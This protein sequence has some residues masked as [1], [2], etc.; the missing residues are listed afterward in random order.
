MKKMICLVFMIC[1]LTQMSTTYAESN[2]KLDY[3]SNRNKSFVSEDVFYKQLDK[4][5]YKEYDNAAYS[6]RKKILFKEVPDEEFSFLQKTAAGCRSEVMLHESFIHPNRQVYFFASFSQNEVKEL[7]KY[8]VI[9]AETKRELRE[10][11]SYHHCN[12]LY[13]K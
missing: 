13:K 3:P 10:G 1:F 9:D 6:V 4:K 12:N 11:K 8:I 7:H 5:I 2:Q